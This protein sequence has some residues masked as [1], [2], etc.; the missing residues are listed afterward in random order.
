M[1]RFPVRL[2]VR[3]R[4]SRRKR[5]P[6]K[7]L[8]LLAGAA[9]LWFCEQGLWSLSPQLLEEAA[10]AHVRSCVE[11]AVSLALEEAEGPFVQVEQDGEGRIVGVQADAA[12]LHQ[13]K[14]K[15]LGKLERTLSGRST[16][17][18]P[19]GSL[20]G[21]ALLNGRGFPVPVRLGFTGS[22]EVE[23]QTELLSAGVNQSCHRITMVVHAR[24]YSQSKTLEAQAEE[25]SASVLAETLIVGEVPQ[26]AVLGR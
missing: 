25:R 6:G 3:Y 10:R 13:V 21:V 5:K 20:T 22:A 4:S 18:V 12:A 7:W 14:E 17:T 26:A 1:A 16:V 19:A 9:L 23:F 11:E 2:P 24:V 15:I 8:L